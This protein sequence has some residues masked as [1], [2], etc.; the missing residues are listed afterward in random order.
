MLFQFVEDSVFDFFVLVIAWQMSCQV[1][2]QRIARLWI[3]R[4]LNLFNNRWLIYDLIDGIDF[5]GLSSAVFCPM[6][7]VVSRW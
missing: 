7:K 6:S 4:K 2:R 5:V 1:V 3:E